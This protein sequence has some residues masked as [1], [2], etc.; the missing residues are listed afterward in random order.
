MPPDTDVSALI[1][2]AVMGEEDALHQLLFF[3][4]AR[5]A[6]AVE[7]LIGKKLRS[8]ISTEDILQETF[9]DAFRKIKEF[10]ARDDR[11]FFSWLKVIAAN[12]VRDAARRQSAKKRGGDLGRVDSSRGQQDSAVFNLL[13]ELSDGGQSPSGEAAVREATD[14]IR[15]A[16]AGLPD[17]QREAVALHWLQGLSLQET[18]ERMGRSW[19]SVR[20]LVQRG[21]QA[22]E[23]RNAAFVHVA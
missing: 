16:I 9:V 15:M 21:K 5:L 7:P 2:R 1:E 3:H 14:A 22:L 20:G 12:R 4:H 8:S 6:T 18:A 13:V 10:D 23:S 19:D 17:D 11:S